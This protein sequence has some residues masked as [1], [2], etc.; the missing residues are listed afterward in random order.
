MSE[1]QAERRFLRLIASLL[2]GA[3]A[4]WV[5]HVGGLPLW[6]S[7]EALKHVAPW[8]IP[9]YALGF[10]LV[11]FV[12]AVRWHWLLRPV[13]DVSM[14]RLLDVSFIGFAAIVLLPLRSGEL[15]RPMMIRKDTTIS[16]WAA[17]GTIA[18]ERIIDGVLVSLFLLLGLLGSTPLDPLP[19]R[20]GNLAV[21]ARLIPGLA[22]SALLLF[23]CAFT[24]M[25]LFYAKHDL[26]VNLVERTVGRV[27][28]RLATWLTTRV[29][30]LASGLGFLPKASLA[31]PFIGLSVLYWLL[32]AA[33]T[34]ALGI[35]CGLEG[36]SFS[37][38][39]V[40]MG[41]LALGI[42]LPNAPG[43]FGAFQ[44]AVYASLAMYYPPGEI[45]SKGAAFVFVQYVVQSAVTLGAA[46]V[47][48]LVE[49]N[50]RDQ[51]AENLP[52][53]EVSR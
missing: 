4:I 49:R 21:P 20:I 34:Q 26:A 16:G 38:A 12:R 25:G 30:Q 13:G 29:E 46:G 36:M 17:T 48:W 23:G 22:Y 31:W 1:P 15:V 8:S 45:D 10:A 24:A 53:S 43:Y 47:A 52:V 33:A 19:D 42:L 11:H 32:N 50:R 40:S 39:C 51:D 5:L 35:G 27:S 41:V 6:P 14:R 7:S 28:P 44:V 3:L 2:A 18:A 37:I 9:A